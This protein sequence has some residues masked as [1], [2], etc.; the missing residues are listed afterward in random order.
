[1][2]YLLKILSRALTCLYLIFFLPLFVL[3]ILC[4]FLCVPFGYIIFGKEAV[5]R[6]LCMS[7]SIIEKIEPKWE[8]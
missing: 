1:M 7:E 4:Y 2:N 6:L 3:I 8:E 5:G